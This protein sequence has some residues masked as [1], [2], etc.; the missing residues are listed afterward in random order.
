MC[1]IIIKKK[2]NNYRYNKRNVFGVMK[3]TYTE[4]N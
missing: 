3:V 2:N 4:K 1:T